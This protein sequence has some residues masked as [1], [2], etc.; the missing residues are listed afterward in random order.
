MDELELVLSTQVENYHAGELEK[1]KEKIIADTNK[2]QAQRQYVNSSFTTFF[3]GCLTSIH[4]SNTNTIQ[5][6]MA[7]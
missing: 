6:S 7:Q 5:A 3:C 1:Y 2:Y 4:I